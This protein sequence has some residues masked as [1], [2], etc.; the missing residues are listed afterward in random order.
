M[1]PSKI[2][3]PNANPAHASVV[4]FTAAIVFPPVMQPNMSAY[5]IS[6]LSVIKFIVYLAAENPSIFAAALHPGMVD[7][8]I[9]RKTGADPQ[10]LP[11]NTGL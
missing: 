3:L 4:T 8:A 7:T 5:A 9:L 6:K 1:L 10:T 11:I 2:F